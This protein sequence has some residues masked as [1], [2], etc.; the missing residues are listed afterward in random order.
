MNE[1]VKGENNSR[2]WRFK[3]RRMEAD[4]LEKGGQ[5]DGWTSDVKDKLAAELILLQDLYLVS[6][7]DY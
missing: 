2:T 1:S 6:L 5:E 7:N 3:V 4:W